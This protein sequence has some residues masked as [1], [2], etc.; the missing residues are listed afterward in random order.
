MRNLKLGVIGNCA[1]G[2]L[3][4]S[5]GDIVWCCLP[6]FDGD[7]VFC[8][9]LND[10]VAASDDGPGTYRI[11]LID[12]V[13]S[14]QEYIKNTAVLV[15]RLYDSAGGAVEITDFAPRYLQLGRMFRPTMIVRIVRP[16]SGEPRVRVV[17]RPAHGY[18]AHAPDVTSGSNHVRYIGGPITLRL[19]TDAPLSFVLD[20]TPFF[21][22]EPITLILGPDETLARPIVTSGREFLENT[23]EFWRRWSR[24]LALPLE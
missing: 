23:L 18:G 6:R 3:V 24:T 14:E 13:R 17:L 2:A 20:E 19:T 10:G 4:D 11:D 12:R 15:T 1:F 9:L 16:L 22:E 5:V 8:R 7:P 21:L